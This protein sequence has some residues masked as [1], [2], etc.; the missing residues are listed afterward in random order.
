MKKTGTEKVIQGTCVYLYN[1]CFLVFQVMPQLNMYN[2][3][4]GVEKKIFLL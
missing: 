1:I 2:L 3:D 4:Y